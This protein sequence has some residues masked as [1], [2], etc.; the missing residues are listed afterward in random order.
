MNR[1][2]KIGDQ[3]VIIDSRAMYLKNGLK[4]GCKTVTGRVIAI[5]PVMAN[6]TRDHWILVKDE[7]CGRSFAAP[8]LNVW[9]I[10]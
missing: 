3:A 2:H 1:N 8:S 6:V 7:G 9:R 5:E 4:T 10:E